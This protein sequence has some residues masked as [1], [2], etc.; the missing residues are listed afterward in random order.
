M[1]GLVRVSWPNSF[2]GADF[3]TSPRGHIDELI[4]SYAL[5]LGQLA[6]RRGAMAAA[7]AQ[8]CFFS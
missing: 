8:N 3:V 4:E 6:P 1:R 2:S 5:R 7:A